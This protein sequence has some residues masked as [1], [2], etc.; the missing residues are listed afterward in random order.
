MS[1]KSR[2]SKSTGGRCS[3]P[4]ERA[5]FTECMWA[6]TREEGSLAGSQDLTKPAS[7]D[8]VLLFSGKEALSSCPGS[9]PWVQGQS[10]WKRNNGA[11]WRVYLWCPHTFLSFRLP[12]WTPMVLLSLLFPPNIQYSV[13]ANLAL[14]WRSATVIL[15][16]LFPFPTHLRI[17]N[18]YDLSKEYL[19]FDKG[20]FLWDG[21]ASKIVT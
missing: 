17:C 5:P 10:V 6:E 8:E 13:S 19:N 21:E 1:H 7:D 12:F 4:V 2:A 18:M 9:Q 20:Y 15:T 14:G 3:Y 11:S 16:F